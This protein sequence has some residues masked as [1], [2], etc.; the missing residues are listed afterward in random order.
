MVNQKRRAVIF[1]ASFVALLLLLTLMYEDSL[2]FKRTKTTSIRS[3]D[4]DSRAQDPRLAAI[5][6]FPQVDN[7]SLSKAGGPKL[8]NESTR[9]S[10]LR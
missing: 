6:A 8:Q 7:D 2:I 3:V 9:Y 10:Q 5:N 4:F 1:L